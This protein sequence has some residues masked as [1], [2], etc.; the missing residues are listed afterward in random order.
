MD[1]NALSDTRLTLLSGSAMLEC[2][3]LL[4]GNAVSIT[5]GN[6]PVQLRK[7]GLFRLQADPPAVAAIKGE[8]YVGGTFNATVKQG[9]MMQL[10]GA[11]PLIAKYKTNKKEPLYLFSKARSEDSVYATG[12]TA[13][14]LLANGFA[15]NCTGS[16]WY[17][18]GG[19]GMYSFVPCNGMMGSPF[20]SY[21]LGVNSAYL[22]AGPTF[23]TAPYGLYGGGLYNPV[24]GRG[25]RPPAQGTTG[26]TVA[27]GSPTK[28]NMPP[29]FGRPDLNHHPIDTARGLR[30]GQSIQNMAGPNLG[31]GHGWG[32]GPR[33]WSTG[34]MAGP[35]MGT[36]IPDASQGH[37][38]GGYA[39]GM[40]SGAGPG[41]YHH[42]ASGGGLS[43]G[44]GMSRGGG[45]TGSGGA[46]N[47]GARSVG[48]GRAGK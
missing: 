35:A 20:G 42:S 8:T 44:G 21:F 13:N 4:A 1:G 45:G 48:G 17:L 11:A 38:G 40:H 23:Y 26:G 47:G 37:A 28:P 14:T 31:R 41:A 32:N 2:D 30:S 9:K 7:R 46:G 39:G 15:G 43:N 34:G 12:V 18:M 19:V 29:T 33:A 27:G 16:N 6:Q 22:W 24:I 5:V 36:G 3:E 10:D 25:Y